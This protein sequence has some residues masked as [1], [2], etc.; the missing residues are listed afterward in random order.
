[1]MQDLKEID[2]PV[3][4]ISLKTNIQ[5]GTFDACEK[6]GEKHERRKNY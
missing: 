5:L 4:G 6:I 2:T 3:F 1:M